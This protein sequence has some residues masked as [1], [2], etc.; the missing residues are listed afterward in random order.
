M[1]SLKWRPKPR[2]FSAGRALG[3]LV[4]L[5]DD[6]AHEASIHEAIRTQHRSLSPAQLPVTAADQ[7]IAERQGAPR[8]G[9]LARRHFQRRTHRAAAHRR[10]TGERQGNGQTWL[11]DQPRLSAP[12]CPSRPDSAWER[13]AP[14][15][16]R[17]C[18]SGANLLML[19]RNQLPLGEPEGWP[20]ACSR[21][22][23]GGTSKRRDFLKNTLATAG[24]ALVERAA[25]PLTTRSSRRAERA[26]QRAGEPGQ[27]PQNA[28]AGSMT[29][30]TVVL[31]TR[32]PAAGGRRTFAMWKVRSGGWGL[33]FD[34]LP[35]T[36]NYEQGAYYRFVSSNDRT[37]P[38]FLNRAQPGLRVPLLRAGLD[39]G[40][41][42]P[43]PHPG[44]LR[45]R[46][47]VRFA[48]GSCNLT[49]AHAPSPCCRT[50]RTWRASTSSFTWA[51]PSTPTSSAGARTP[52]KASTVATS[53]SGRAPAG[54]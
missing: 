54:R 44:Q 36:A 5:D 48:A 13:R 20:P 37:K 40:A 52:R 38:G 39:A 28:W 7:R 45:Q 14:A 18:T 49:G 26:H 8:E 53:S 24:T 17:V 51:T 1:W 30:D 47:T 41:A 10:A 29:T 32:H 21:Q 22:A 27:V 34:G 16:A 6:A 19:R 25:A 43:L 31:T 50:R 42:V 3:V 9:P 2:S 23:H 35:Q 15:K 12:S 11:G 46:A 33:V 4:P